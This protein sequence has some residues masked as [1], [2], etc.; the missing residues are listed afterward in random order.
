MTGWWYLSFADDSGFLGG[1]FVPAADFDS[2]LAKTHLLRINP[3]GEV[4]GGGPIDGKLIQE[5]LKPEHRQSAV[6]KGDYRGTLRRYPVGG[7]GSRAGE[8]R[9]SVSEVRKE[10]DWIAG[11]SLY[12]CFRCRLFASWL[13]LAAPTSGSGWAG[14]ASYYCQ[15]HG[16]ERYREVGGIVRTRPPDCPVESLA[17]DDKA[18]VAAGAFGPILGPQG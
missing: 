4:R 9:A 13:C 7:I 14:R 17:N 6:V 15:A 16:S 10:W 18:T 1:A 5:T 2:A 11:Q 3:G 12:R 8:G